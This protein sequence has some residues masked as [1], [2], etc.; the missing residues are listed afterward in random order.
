MSTATA[1]DRLRAR[2]WGVFNHFLYGAP[3]SDLPDRPDA[4]PWNDM[5]DS[6]DVERVARD[7][8]D[9]GAGWYFLT[10]MQGRKYMVAPNATFDAIAGTVPGEA[11][12]RRDLVA[13]LVEALRRYD[14]DLFLYFTGDGPYKDRAVGERF[15]FG[16]ERGR[17][18]AEFVRKWTSV[19]EEYA[20]RY[21]DRVH[22]WWFDGV[23]DAFGYNDELMEPYH[24]AAK[25]GNPDA[26]TAFNNG[27][28][29]ECRRWFRDEEMTAGE[30]NGFTHVPASRFVD[31]AQAFL[32]APLGVAPDGVEWN[33]W[34]RPGTQ[35][36]IAT[37]RA[38]QQRLREVGAV[39]TIDIFVG[40]D[41]S[42]DP[43]QK[44]LL[45]EAMN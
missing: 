14:I 5:V 24:R 19:L 29:P 43:A 37:L 39:L 31:G 40:E 16:P 35:V 7:L 9:I 12:A 21:G 2:R 8:H 6:F 44:A 28:F 18:D 3:G 22:G 23:Y 11:C 45:K 41:G 1:L 15:G 10:V 4:R 27:V 25:K 34:R 26:L 42:W 17:I 36:D 33:R 13:D 20:V 32:L 38:Y 30:F